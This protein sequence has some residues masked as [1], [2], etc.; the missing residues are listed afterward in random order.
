MYNNFIAFAQ[1]QAALSGLRSEK[2]SFYRDFIL[3][4]QLNGPA[5]IGAL[6][7]LT[8]IGPDISF[9]RASSA[10]YID[11]NGNI[12]MANVNEPR[13]EWG[14]HRTNL[15]SASNDISSSSW[16]GY[17]TKSPA[18]RQD[19]VGPDRIL[20]SA[21]SLPL[22][23]A[24]Y[25]PELSIPRTGIVQ[26][27]TPLISGTPITVSAWIRSDDNT[28]AGISFGTSDGFATD[29]TNSVTR[30]WRR[31]SYTSFYNPGVGTGARG[32]QFFIT[33]GIN[34]NNASKVYI[35]GLQCEVGSTATPYI[36]TGARPVTVSTPKG[37]LIEEQRTNYVGQQN[38][39]NWT[40]FSNTLSA[41]SGIAG[42]SSFIVGD[43]SDTVAGTAQYA[44][45]SPLLSATTYCFSCFIKKNPN[46]NNINPLLR[47]YF[48]RQD[49]PGDINRFA[50]IFFNQATGQ[51]VTGYSTTTSA[52][53]VQDFG[54]YYR[55]SFTFSH[56]TTS[57]NTYVQLIPSH[58]SPYSVA[59]TGTT[60]EVAGIQV[61][62]GTFPTSYIP[63]NGLSATRTL[64][65][66]Q[67]TS[68]R[69][70]TMYNNKEGSLFVEGSVKS[71]TSTPWLAVVNDTTFNNRLGIFTRMGATPNFV[72]AQFQRDNVPIQ[73][74]TTNPG[75]EQVNL[76]NENIVRAATNYNATSASLF[77]N[78]FTVGTS[79]ITLPSQ[80]SVLHIGRYQNI[81]V[82][83]SHIRK[84]GYWPKRLS[85]TTLQALTL[86]SIGFAKYFA[87]DKS[88]YTGT[89]PGVEVYRNSSATYFDE[90]GILR[91][92]GANRP[93]FD[94]DPAT[95]T[96]KGLLVEEQRTNKLLQS[97]NFNATGAWFKVNNA[98]VISN[99]IT[100][101]DGTR[102]GNK[103]IIPLAGYIVGIYS[104]INTKGNVHTF[105]AYMKA[106]E[107]TNGVLSFGGENN[108]QGAT[109]DLINGTVTGLSPTAIRDLFTASITPANNG[110]F[111]C[112]VTGTI[113]L[114][115]VSDAIPLIASTATSLDPNGIYVWGAQFEQGAFPTSYTPTAGAQV[116]RAADVVQVNSGSFDT[117][118]NPEQ[119]TFYAKVLPLSG[120]QTAAIIDVGDTYNSIH[121]IWKS[122][123]G[124]DGSVGTQW[125]TFSDSY[126]LS[127]G[128]Q[129]TPLTSNFTSL[130]NTANLANRIAYTYGP[131]FATAISTSL[132][133][134]T[135]A[136]SALPSLEGFSYFNGHIQSL[137]Y[138]NTRLTTTQLTALS[139]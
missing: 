97:Q 89:G 14:N 64:D 52:V 61:E 86:S 67:V 135:T 42:L 54:T 131:T 74:T 72:G 88:L 130:P 47:M 110:W 21:W 36:S 95:G 4:S 126:F 7:S 45:P 37:L 77:V 123:E 101:P 92:V 12:A 28:A 109:F 27:I 108:N 49:V 8:R 29:I 128:A 6:P 31:Y 44:F 65:I 112:S 84:L 79:A 19:T 127:A 132:I 80:I 122:G 85:N 76:R 120:A 117:F 133:T 94:H 115:A 103:V 114:T 9:V 71:P 55:T 11:R 34:T 66:A 43:V 136:V 104:S 116:T 93:R 62:Q 59:L 35:Y 16:L 17:F 10:T 99:A 129:Y 100:A 5:T 3:D 69:F 56:P 91:T 107:L 87:Q 24:I 113:P 106:G 68:N 32:T 51:T 57:T 41:G 73:I 25:G 38:L 26:N 50:G 20:N 1:Q 137:E 90:N 18:W 30:D 138:Y 23:A 2:P 39:F 98:A 46:F 139:N 96:S 82:L 48:V 118:Y 70:A 78:G 58:G 33:S 13:F 121:G 83:N 119:G 15:L 124:G 22:S 60:L 102:T 63:T 53:S 81:G 134:Q 75:T 111:R 105:S 125:N 40:Q